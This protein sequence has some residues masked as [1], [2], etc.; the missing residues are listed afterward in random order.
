MLFSRASA[1]LLPGPTG[2]AGQGPGEG[3]CGPGQCHPAAGF[4]QK[5][6]R[7]S[8]APWADASGHALQDHMLGDWH[9]VPH[10]R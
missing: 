3:H 8:F 4:G 2:G 10:F 6:G 1:R 5:G 7:F 9:K